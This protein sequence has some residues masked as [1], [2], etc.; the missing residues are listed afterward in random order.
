MGIYVC[1][2]FNQVI[3][4]KSP[5][6][7]LSSDSDPLFTFYRWQANLRILE[8]EEIKTVPY[9]PISHPFVERLIGTCRR[10]FLD[11]ILFWNNMIYKIN[12]RHSNV[13]ITTIVAMRVSMHNYPQ[14]NRLAMLKTWLI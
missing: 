12:W 4:G 1:F 9:V 10:E 14:K 6:K 7:Y 3:S 8:I 2:M 11:K 13:I 5:P